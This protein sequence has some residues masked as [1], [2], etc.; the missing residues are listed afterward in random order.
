[1]AAIFDK[2]EEW[3]LPP[4]CRRL[5]PFFLASRFRSLE[6]WLR[7][8]SDQCISF[9]DLHR[10]V[11]GD[12]TV[13][14]AVLYLVAELWPNRWRFAPKEWEPNPDQVANLL[15]SFSNL[16]RLRLEGEAKPIGNLM[17]HVLEWYPRIED[18]IVDSR[19]NQDRFYEG[20]EEELPDNF[21][22]SNLHQIQDGPAGSYHPC[23]RDSEN[24]S[25]KVNLVPFDPSR[26]SKPCHSV[27][28]WSK[29]A[30]NA[31]FLHLCTVLRPSSLTLV[32]FAR[33]AELS[34]LLLTLQNPSILTHLSLFAVST[35]NNDIESILP[36]FSNL[37]SLA[38]GGQ[39]CPSTP[40]FYDQLSQFQLETLHFGPAAEVLIDDVT[41]LVED[42]QRKIPTL[43]HLIMD[44]V[45][46]H[47]PR[48][49]DDEGSYSLGEFIDPVWPS[50]C[51]EEGVERLEEIAE[52]KVLLS[53]K[54]FEALTYFES[55]EYENAVKVERWA[56]KEERERIREVERREKW[57]EAQRNRK[58][59]QY[60]AYPDY[61]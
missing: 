50:R 29:S 45:D 1:L 18:W 21:E 6:M 51:T 38:L 22:L 14:P 48:S 23:S 9:K 10:Y 58:A 31:T 25:V 17:R 32:N 4:L 26:P 55:E 54:T 56:R 43:R 39:A 34:S 53:G 57:R 3:R 2:L 19:D 59:S 16:R 33:N 61:Y 49:G 40:S 15:S 20:T 60:S 11:Q 36:T 8:S 13:A 37:V 44:N 42:G 30:H 27:Y 5:Y 35:S 46:F 52:G 12:P 28:L 41:S 24:V 7:K 47:I